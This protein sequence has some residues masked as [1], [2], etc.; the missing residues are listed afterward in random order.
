MILFELVTG[1]RPYGD[2][3]DVLTARRPDDAH[4]NGTRGGRHG[5]AGDLRGHRPRAWRGNPADRFQTAGE[6]EAELQRLLLEGS[7][8]RP[9]ARRADQ[10]APAG[11]EDGAYSGYAAWLLALSIVAVGAAAIPFV[12]RMR[13]ASDAV[14]TERPVIAVLPLENLTGDASKGHLGVGIA[15]TMTTSLGRLSSISVV[16][17]SS[18]LEA[19]ASTR[20]L[21][22]IARNLGVTMLLRGSIQ[23]AGDLLRVDAKLESL[24]GQLLWSD[25]GEAVRAS[26]LRCRISSPNRCSPRCASGSPRQNARTSH[27]RQQR[28]RRRLTRTITAL[29]CWTARTT[30]TSTRPLPTS[31][32]RRHAIPYSRWR[33]PRCGEAYRRRSVRTNDAALMDK[34]LK[35]VTEALRLDAEQPEVR[36]SRARVYRS[37]G[38]PGVAVIEV[39]RVLAVQPENDNAHRLL[40]E[41]LAKAGQPRKRSKRFAKRPTCGRITGS[42]R[43]RSDCSFMETASFSKPLTRSPGSRELKPNDAMPFQQLGAM[44]LN[45]GDFARAR[46]NFEKSN[47]LRPNAGSFADLGSIAYSGSRYNDAVRE[48]EAGGEAGTDYRGAPWQSGRCLSETRPQADALA[49]YRKAIKFGEEALEVNPNDVTTVSRLGVYYAKLGSPRKPS[50]TRTVPPGR[51]PPIRRAVSPSRCAGAYRPAGCRDAAIVGRHRPWLRDSP[52]SQRRRPGNPAVASGIPASCSGEIALSD[53]TR[54]R[55][56]S[57]RPFHGY[58]RGRSAAAAAN[59]DDWIRARRLCRVQCH[60]VLILWSM[61]APMSVFSRTCALNFPPVAVSF[62]IAGAHHVGGEAQVHGWTCPDFAPVVV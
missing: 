26:C 25:G 59:D 36:L 8:V 4:P 5:R 38:R 15:D 53:F 42:T 2:I 9:A 35:A 52:G 34:A 22:E 39:K 27:A 50:G 33:S 14:R 41:L 7:A 45:Q 37:T 30:Q 43:K 61:M 46:E 32:E 29:R 21:T 1:Q 62:F 10:S 3:F 24:D 55:P 51:T 18:M 56:P 13:S 48:Y 44:H 16:P 60:K 28:T 19:G 20:P 54:F 47:K 49:A 40:G 31:I 6:L 57:S 11:I 12:N 17:R 23:Q 58:C